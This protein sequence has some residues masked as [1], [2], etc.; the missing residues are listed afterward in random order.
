MRF[1]CLTFCANQVCLIPLRF[2]LQQNLMLRDKVDP[3]GCY[4]PKS[5]NQRIRH[6]GN[7]IVTNDTICFFFFA[8]GWNYANVIERCKSYHLHHLYKCIIM[9]RVIMQLVQI[10]TKFDPLNNKFVIARSKKN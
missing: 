8:K 1:R 9:H 5:V 10:P 7:E 4:F 3:T 2:R 6:H